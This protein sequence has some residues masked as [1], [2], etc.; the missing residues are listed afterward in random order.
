[1]GYDPRKFSRRGFEYLRAWPN[2]EA[3]TLSPYD[4]RE[5]VLCN[6]VCRVLM[7][8]DDLDALE[9]IAMYRKKPP[10]V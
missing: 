3:Q 9:R 7:A 6:K 5:E 8:E 4:Q 10:S 1:M 2:N